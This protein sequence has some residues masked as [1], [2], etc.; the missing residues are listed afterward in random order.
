LGRIQV[1][2]NSFPPR[3]YLGVREAAKEW[4]ALQGKVSR[5]LR[6]TAKAGRASDHPKVA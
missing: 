5:E 3:Y 4:A 1:Y 6:V 2:Q